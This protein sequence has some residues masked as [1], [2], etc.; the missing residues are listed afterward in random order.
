MGR[1]LSKELIPEKDHATI[2]LYS[3]DVGQIRV[4]L[5]KFE[6][7]QLQPSRDPGGI[8]HFDSGSGG[9]GYGRY[10]SGGRGGMRDGG[11]GG[12]GGK[13]GNFGGRG[14]MRAGGFGGRVGMRDGAVSGHGHGGRSNFFPGRSNRDVGLVVLVVVMLV[15]VG[16]NVSHMIGT[17]IWMGVDG[18]VGGEDTTTEE[19]FIGREAEV[20]AVALKKLEHGVI[21][22]AA[23]AAVAEAEVGVG[24]GTGVVATAA[25]LA[26]AVVVA[27]ATALAVV[28]DV[29]TAATMANM[30]GHMKETPMRKM[31]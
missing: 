2:V 26:T 7:Q 25:A 9:D 31:L 15:G 4:A 24:A 1:T 18:D 5:T 12:R 28:A 23:A 16:M 11:F 29:A 19:T 13:D 17:T 6:V 21:A 22:E 8:S 14:G 30:R 20:I 10:D 27:T 3:S